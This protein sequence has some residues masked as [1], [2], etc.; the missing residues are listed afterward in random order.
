MLRER[1]I[2]L[3]LTVLQTT[4]TIALAPNLDEEARAKAIAIISGIG[5]AIN[6]RGTTVLGGLDIVG[7]QATLEEGLSSTN[8]TKAS[9]SKHVVVLIHGI[10]T[11]AA[12]Y[13]PVSKV[14][15]EAGFEVERTNFG[16]FDLVCFYH[17]FLGSGIALL[18]V[19]L[20]TFTM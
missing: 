14:L 2:D 17:R 8:A 10:R 6:D 5:T 3:Y 13:E 19:S 7:P 15:I 11:W 16:R 4:Q 9:S 1:E 12:W 20:M 18:E